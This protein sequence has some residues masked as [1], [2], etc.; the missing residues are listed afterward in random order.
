MTDNCEGT[1][2]KGFFKNELDE[3]IKAL[4]EIF[5]IV[6]VLI[7][8]GLTLYGIYTMLPMDMQTALIGISQKIIQNSHYYYVMA[9]VFML[10]FLISVFLWI[11][12]SGIFLSIAGDPLRNLRDSNKALYRICVLLIVMPL[13]CVAYVIV[14]ESKSVDALVSTIM[15]ILP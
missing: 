1:G 6:K 7:I 12:F 2:I 15:H 11:I 14:H 9:Y 5:Y 4:G 8:T 10:K 13:G 3:F